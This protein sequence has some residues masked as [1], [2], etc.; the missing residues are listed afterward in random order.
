LLV[1]TTTSLLAFRQQPDFAL[2]AAPSALK[3]KPKAR[4][5]ASITVASQGGFAGSVG[6]TVSGV[7]GGAKAVL[8][9]S[10]VSIDSTAAG[11]ATLTVTAGTK[12]ASFTLMVQACAQTLCHDTSV[13]VQIAK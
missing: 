3:L 11:N 6:L 9:P 7:A 4:A 8:N 1:P 10:T 5:S 13:L 12:A 2:T